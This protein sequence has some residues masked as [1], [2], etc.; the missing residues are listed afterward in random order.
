MTKRKVTKAEGRKKT[1]VSC[2]LENEQKLMIQTE[3][4][5]EQK[6]YGKRKRDLSVGKPQERAGAWR[7]ENGGKQ[8]AP[9]HAGP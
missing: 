8:V 1:S 9:D 7:S 6:A 5:C 3:K 4:E 2:A